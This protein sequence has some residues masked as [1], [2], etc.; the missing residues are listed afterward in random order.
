MISIAGSV[1][2]MPAV[3]GPFASQRTRTSLVP[4]WWALITTA[5]TFRMMSVTSSMTPVTEVNSWSAPVILTLVMAAPSRLL[6]STRRS[7]FPTVI[8]KPRSNGSMRNRPYVG[9]DTV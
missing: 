6:R 5:L 7:E 4:S 3:T 9:V 8:P 1:S 2:I